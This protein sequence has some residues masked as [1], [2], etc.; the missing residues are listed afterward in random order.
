MATGEQFAHKWEFQALIEDELV[1]FLRIDIVHAGGIT[2]TKKIMAAGEITAAICVPPRQLADQRRGLPARRHGDTELR[3]PG[4]DGAR[5]ALRASPRRASGGGW[6]RHPTA[7]PGLG[8]EFDETE[9]RKRPSHDA[10]PPQ[11]Y[12]PDGS[13]GDY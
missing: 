11:R 4:M 1:D 7:G 3:H 13:V 5:A 12:W 10:S 8:L 9:A 2:E 6:L